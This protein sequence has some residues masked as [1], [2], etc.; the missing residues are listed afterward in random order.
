MRRATE[1]QKP[2][3]LFL[4]IYNEYIPYTLRVNAI[5]K[6][7][8]KTIIKY[9]WKAQNSYLRACVNKKVKN[10]RN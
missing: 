7:Y 9:Y 10:I 1:L 8:L 2:L 6:D 5:I 3:F 4:F